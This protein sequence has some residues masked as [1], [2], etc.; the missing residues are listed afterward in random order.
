VSIL[1][2]Q[3]IVDPNHITY[4]RFLVCLILLLFFTHLS[5]VQILIVATLGGLS[6]FF[7]GAFARSASKKTRLGVLIDPFADKVLI[8]TIMYILLMKKVLDPIYVIL[9]VIMELHIVI[10]PILSWL[11]SILKGKN[12]SVISK[13]K[14]ANSVFIRSRPV[15]LGRMKVH[16]YSS[17]GYENADTAVIFY[18]PC[19]PFRKSPYTILFCLA[20]EEF[21]ASV[22]C[23]FSANA[24]S[25]LPVD[26]LADVGGYTAKRIIEIVTS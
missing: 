13:Q 20:D 21:P 3:D 8:F 19:F 22:T 26:G 9:M 1:L 10:V 4:F 12:T 18:L 17:D 24:E 23:L 7:D 14:A 5:Y 15:F 2:K 16:L 11:H 6:D 25:F